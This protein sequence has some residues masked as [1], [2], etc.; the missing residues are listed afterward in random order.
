MLV[1]YSVA[2]KWEDPLIWMQGIWPGF[3]SAVNVTD[4][5]NNGY[6]SVA[7]GRPGA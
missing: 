2:R 1:W 5:M 6:C 3:S 7:F 4:T